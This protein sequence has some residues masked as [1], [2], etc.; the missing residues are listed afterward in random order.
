MVF[1]IEGFPNAK[2][3]FIADIQCP[4]PNGYVT[5][6]IMIDQSLSPLQLPLQY[7]DSF[8]YRNIFFIFDIF[9]II[10]R[11]RCKD[12]RYLVKMKNS[13]DTPTDSFDSQCLWNKTLSTMPSDLEC[14]LTFC[15][16]PHTGPGSHAPPP[17][18]NNL[19]LDV[20]F[21]VSIRLGENVTYK[22]NEGMF[23][24]NDTIFHPMKTEMQVECIEGVGEYNTPVIAGGQWPNCTATVN[25]GP[26]PE[27]PVN[28]TRSWMNAAMEGKDSYNTSIQY[29]CEHGS[30]F[31]TN[32]DGVGE[33]DAVAIQ[34]LWN[35]QWTP[36]ASLP[37][38]IITHCV[39]PFQ[40]P[41]ESNLIEITQDLTPINTFKLYECKNK[42]DSVHTMFWESDRSKSTHELF[43]NPDGSFTWKKWP[44]CLE[45][46]LI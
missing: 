16:H 15:S 8:R 31:D 29:T 21:D 26:P 45:G 22:C 23:F 11:W 4:D 28:G 37:P 39:E 3:M 12:N 42:I 18:E 46:E 19:H 13:I 25:C 10:P 40:I 43:C 44:R 36:H 5:E 14:V 41:Q 24:E 20:N 34:C 27:P 30:K 38:C 9:Y 7:E 1:F 35:K 6:L 33:S 17:S 2:Y 32:D